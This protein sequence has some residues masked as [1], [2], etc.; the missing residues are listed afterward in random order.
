MPKTLF[1]PSKPVSYTH[2]DV[3]KRQGGVFKGESA[4]SEDQKIFEIKQQE[5]NKTPL[6]ENTGT[7]FT[8]QKPQDK[9]PENHLKSNLLM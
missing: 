2:L 1:S 7:S 6:S 9:I 4:I 3:Y 5:E 8:Q